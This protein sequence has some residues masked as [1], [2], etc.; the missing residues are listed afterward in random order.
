MLLLRNK[1]LHKCYWESFPSFIIR[2]V[3]YLKNT[4]YYCWD[5]GARVLCSCLKIYQAIHQSIKYRASNAPNWCKSWIPTPTPPLKPLS[6][7]LVISTLSP[8][9]EPSVS[10]KMMPRI[11]YIIPNLGDLWNRWANITQLAYRFASVFCHRISGRQL[12]PADIA[13]VA[14]Q[15]ARGIGPILRWCWASVVDASCLLDHLLAG[16]NGVWSGRPVNLVLLWSV[17][18]S[19]W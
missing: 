1:Y 12:H 18:L 4:A 13:L 3:V 11:V 6:I 8:I 9:F 2:L 19:S 5:S 17:W 7:L 10:T 16:D 14:P 15:Q